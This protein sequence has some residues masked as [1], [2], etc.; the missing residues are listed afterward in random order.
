MYSLSLPGRELSTARSRPFGG[1][2]VVMSDGS[3]RFVVEGISQA[4][5]RGLGTRNGGELVD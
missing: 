2:N 5:W 4:V 1:V 3:S